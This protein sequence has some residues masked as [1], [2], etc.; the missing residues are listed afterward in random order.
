MIYHQILKI[1]NT[2]DATSRAGIAYPSEAP[3]FTSDLLGFLL[4][5]P[6]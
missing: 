3:V 5:L 4:L 6:V 1:S 2:T